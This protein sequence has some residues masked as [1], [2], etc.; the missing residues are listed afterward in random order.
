MRNAAHLIAS[1]NLGARLRHSSKESS[2]RMSKP[3]RVMA[4]L[5]ESVMERLMRWIGG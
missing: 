1:L 5:A 3:V 4:N 2:S